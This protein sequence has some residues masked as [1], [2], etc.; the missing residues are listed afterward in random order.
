MPPRGAKGGHGG[1]SGAATGGGAASGGA[2]SGGG[3]DSDDASPATDAVARAAELASRVA[4]LEAQIVALRE[5]HMVA[6]RE[7]E[8]EE[9]ATVNKLLK[10][11]DAARAE[12]VRLAA[13]VGGGGALDQHVAASHGPAGGGES[14]TG[15]YTHGGAREHCQPSAAHGDG[16]TAGEKRSRAACVSGAQLS[17]AAERIRSAVHALA[18][19]T[20]GADGAGVDDAGWLS[21]GSVLSLVDAALSTPATAPTTA[22]TMAS[23]SGAAA[24]AGGGTS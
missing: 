20:H 4:A 12:K 17:A 21:V 24:T 5:S 14:N 15:A 11:L 16:G 9:E 3:E 18:T 7:A 13:A 2:A 22:P 8:K 19:A 10:R 6:L 23:S 1:G